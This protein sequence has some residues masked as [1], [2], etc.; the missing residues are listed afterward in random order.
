MIISKDMIITGAVIIA[1]DTINDINAD[2]NK[3]CSNINFLNDKIIIND[4]AIH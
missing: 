2:K 4:L 3:R 1:S